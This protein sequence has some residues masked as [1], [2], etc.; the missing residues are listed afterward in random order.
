ML[1]RPMRIAA[2][3]LRRFG[4]AAPSEPVKPSIT[5]L[6]INGKFVDATEGKTFETVDPR[7]EE[8]VADFQSA[9]KPDVDKAVAAARKAFDEGPWPRMSGQ[10][11]GQKLRKLAD[12]IMENKERLAKLET[13]DNGKPLFWSENADIPLSASHLQYH[14]GWADKV[15]GETL[16]HATSQGKFFA[17]TLKEPIGV[18]GQIIPWNFPLLMAA[19]KLGPALATGNTIVLK[20]SEKTPI[21]ALELGRLCLEAGIPEGVVNVVPGMG[22][23]AGEALASHPDVN[24]IAFTGSVATAKRIGQVAGIKPIT[25]ELGG[26]SPA[27]VFADCDVDH[28]VDQ[29]H[30]GLF[31]NHGQCCCASS[32]IF[33]HE[34]IYDEFVEKSVAK[35][36]ARSVG[37]PFTEVDQGPQVDQIQFNRI[38][39]YIDSGRE[40]GLNLAV[41][42]ARATDKGYFVQPTIFI[43]VPDDA[44][45]QKEEIFGPVMGITKFSDEAEVIRRANDT[46]FGLASSIFSNNIH[47]VT[48][49]SR[50]IK[51]G[52]VWVNCHNIFDNATPFGGYKESGVGREKGKDALNNYL[53]TKTV[54]MPIQ[55]DPAWL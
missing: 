40:A 22:P 24:K 26:K 45:L 43:D 46:N 2:P 44:K 23:E 3:A 14:A 31:F 36:K 18:A 11:R 32:R 17:Y 54:T 19:W 12:L 5:Q 55:G 16:P 37:D 48:R 4:S 29:V 30:F 28:A 8:K 21:T 39:S 13:L 27:L 50:H 9:T 7:N 25:T 34:S 38:M 53:M 49:V 20:P 15:Y 41:G 10:E 42:G 51:A 47:T 33:V 1:S 35:A 6:L 52:T